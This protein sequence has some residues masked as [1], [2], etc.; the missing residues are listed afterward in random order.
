MINITAVSYINTL[1]FI[2]GIT[3]SGLLS[4]DE[5]RLVR[6]YP[7]LCT[8]AFFDG[9]ADIV[10]IPS[11]S[12]GEFPNEN[13]ITPFCIAANKEVLSVLLLSNVPIQDVR[14]ILLDYQSTTSVKL[15]KLLIKH[16][17]KIDVALIPAT[18]GYEENIKDNTAGLIIGDRALALSSQFDYVY[19]LSLEWWNMTQLP[20]VFAFWAKT[21]NINPDFLHRFEKSLQWGV[22]HKIE[23]LSLCSTI[24]SN[25]QTYID[26]LDRHIHFVL[27]DKAK[28]GLI[29]FYDLLKQ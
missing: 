13:I 16:W 19:D 26:Y 22:E 20:F 15:I 3:Q 21:R 10:L 5:Y 28:Q 7:S 18:D 8:K 29:R 12:F 27:D 2:Y 4:S 24:V 9:T 25:Q 14:Q 17:W 23:S 6:A 1:P 11:G